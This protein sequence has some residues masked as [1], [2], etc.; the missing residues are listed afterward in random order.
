VK[1]TIVDPRRFEPIRTALAIAKIIHEVHPTEWTF[2]AMDNMLR[3][4]PAMDAI[5][6]GKDVAEIEATWTPGL[7]EFRTHRQRFLLYR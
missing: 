5:R 1:I 4:T 2:D 7:D 6:A 3:W